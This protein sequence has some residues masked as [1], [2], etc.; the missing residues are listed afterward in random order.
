MPANVARPLPVRAVLFDLDGTLIDSAPDLG[1]AVNRMRVARGLP[2]LAD[3]VLRP[4]ASHGARGL[5]SVGFNL[6]PDH[7]DFLA[8]REEFLAGYAAALCER[9]VLF[10]GVTR[11]LDALEAARLPWGIVT[12]KSTRL[13]LPL[14]DALALRL[15]PGCIV[16][17]D[18][19]ARAKPHPEPLLAAASLL[20]VLPG[21][22]VYVG[23]AERDVEAG[24]AAG[25]ITLIARYG[26]IRDD[27]LPDE[28]L[29]EGS[30]AAPLD[31]L[32]WLPTKSLSG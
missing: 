21:E 6:T 19:T 29:A 10:P 11:V 28:W 18:T 1:A 32:D 12:N 25:M 5:V 17:G 13:T 31:L 26:Y 20:G 15:R 7:P 8:L 3:G 24:K 14:L 30:L 23:D 4:H 27:E 2:A 22:C 16:C 9:T